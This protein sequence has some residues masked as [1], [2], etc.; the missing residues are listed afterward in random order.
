M[1]FLRIQRA[2]KY[3]MIIVSTFPKTPE[4]KW[5]FVNSFSTPKVSCCIKMYQ[6]ATTIISW[7]RYFLSCTRIN[8]CTY[9]TIILWKL[10][11]FSVIHGSI[12]SRMSCFQSC[13]RKSSRLF[14]K[15]WRPSGQEVQLSYRTLR[16]LLGISLW[17]VAY[18]QGSEFHWDRVCLHQGCRHFYSPHCGSFLSEGLPRLSFWNFSREPLEAD[19]RVQLASGLV[20]LM[21]LELSVLPLHPCRKYCW[22]GRVTGQS[23]SYWGAYTVVHVWVSHRNDHQHSHKTLTSHYH[24]GP[25]TD[26]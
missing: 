21:I 11:A 3:E 17:L 12:S 23:S 15:A 13:Q 1:R 16:G 20:G 18:N 2:S 7:T 5:T 9:P 19:Q 6:D 24:T 8:K 26:E 4:L 25:L 14:G 22:K 10:A